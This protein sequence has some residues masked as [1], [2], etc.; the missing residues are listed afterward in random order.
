MPSL[1]RARPGCCR[2][3]RSQ[4]SA[5]EAGNTAFQA[6]R[7]QDAFQS[8]STALDADTELRTPFIAQCASNRYA[9]Y[10]F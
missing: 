8:Y 7:W 9:F 5:K 6:G 2:R 10:M 4:I 3:V 1:K